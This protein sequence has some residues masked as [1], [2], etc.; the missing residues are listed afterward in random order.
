MTPPDAWPPPTA[1]APLAVLVSGGLDSAVLLAEAAR[2][3]PAVVPIY[4]RV[5]MLWEDAERVHLDRFLAAVRTP[6]LRPLVELDQPAADLYGGHWS[7]TGTDTPGATAAH[8]ADFLPG[9]N[10][11]LFA[12][13]LL[14]CHLHRVPELATAPLGTNPFPDATPAFYDG[15]AAVVARG[16]NLPP[17]RILRPYARLTKMDVLRRGLGFPLEHTFSCVRPVGMV[18]C[19]ACI[20]CGE[21]RAGFRAAGVPDPT[22]YASLG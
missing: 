15:L 19:G 4:V 10:V 9:R 21:R 14:W 18:P 5:G 12:K 3:Y 16:M 8:D 22:V 13:P 7:V 6:A 2:A 1:D 17:V 20:K 11:L